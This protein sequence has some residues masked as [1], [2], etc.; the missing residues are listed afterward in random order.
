VR[1]GAESAYLAGGVPELLVAQQHCYIIF[2][3]QR[4]NP[5]EAKR[6]S[7]NAI[8]ASSGV[9]PSATG[10]GIGTGSSITSCD[11]ANQDDLIGSVASLARARST[12][13]L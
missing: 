11:D 2:L 8:V 1:N 10:S 4:Q 3:G 9:C 13:R 12:I 7:K 6:L 5:A